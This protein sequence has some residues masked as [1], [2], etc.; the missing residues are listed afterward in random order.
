[1][2]TRL[3]DGTPPD[4]QWVR[5]VMQRDIHTVLDGLPV[6]ELDAVECSSA[7]Y[8]DLGWRRHDTVSY[9]DLDLTDPPDVL[10]TYD[11][12]V[13]EQVLEHVTDPWAA[14]VTLRR[15]C[16][17]GGRVIVSTPFLLR[18]HDA[19]GDYW[20]FT[21]DGLRIVL[22]RAGLEVD[23]IESWGNRAAVRANLY[24]WAAQRPWRSLRNV[25]D[26]PTVVWAFARRPLGSS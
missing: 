4:R 24:A 17:P 2:T 6:A 1:L 13:C 20:R 8:A 21:P 19:P 15:L 16:R 14:A 25:A 7:T 18:I 10:P 3:R 26:A 12:V 5:T 9:A 22:E 11:V 23:R